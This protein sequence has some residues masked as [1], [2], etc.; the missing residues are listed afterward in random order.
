MWTATDFDLSKTWLPNHFVPLIGKASDSFIDLVSEDEFPPLHSTVLE[1]TRNPCP[2]LFDSTIKSPPMHIASMSGAKET[3][4]RHNAS[5]SDVDDYI[6]GHNAS[7]SCADDPSQEHNASLSGADDYF[8]GHIA[9][10]S[11]A[12]DSSQ[13]HNASLSGADDIQGHNASMSGADESNQGHNAS[14]SGAEELGY[15]LEG[16]FLSTD[17]IVEILTTQTASLTAIPKSA[18]ENVYFLLDNKHNVDRKNS[19]KR[20]EFFDNCGVWDS[21]STSVKPTY[22]VKSES[23]KLVSCVKKQGLFC[24]EIRKKFIPL[25]PQPDDSNLFILKRY[26]A[27]LKRDKNYELELIKIV[28][29]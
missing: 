8:Q 4:Q 21:K 23:G 7:M 25:E 19:S 24:K 20:M 14:L 6:Q 11:G 27:N 29:Q 18:K 13:E 3:S 15:V 5:M 1:S 22:F 9:S 16:K 26:Y 28:N 12:D 2:T 17:K 10:T